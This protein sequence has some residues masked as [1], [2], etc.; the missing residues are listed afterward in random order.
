MYSGPLPTPT[1]I[2]IDGE[3]VSVRISVE[4]RLLEELLE[5]LSSVPF[6]INPEIHH[7]IP[8]VSNETF[9]EFPAYSDRLTEVHRALQ[10]FGLG[11]LGLRIES[12]LIHIQAN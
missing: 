12:M 1:L 6:P 2:G 9:V 5:A 3:L 11:A 4:P 10:A 7:A 8:G